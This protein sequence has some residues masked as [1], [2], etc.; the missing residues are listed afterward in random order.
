MQSL[1]LIDYSTVRVKITNYN[2]TL[3]MPL[4]VGKKI[5]MS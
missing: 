4:E 3:G 5:V 2:E 1:P